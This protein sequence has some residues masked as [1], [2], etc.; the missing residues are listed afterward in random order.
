M[1]P[2]SDPGHHGMSESSSSPEGELTSQ[3]SEGDSEN[4][5]S[6]IDHS[7]GGYHEVDQNHESIYEPKRVFPPQIKIERKFFSELQQLES[8]I[9]S[10][11]SEEVSVFEREK[12]KNKSVI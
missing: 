12:K 4:S 8:L 11:G 9:S 5:V 2:L 7:V 3:I 6:E 10:N 1:D